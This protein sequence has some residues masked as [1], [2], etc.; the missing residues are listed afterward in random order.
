M[1]GSTL[2]DDCLRRKALVIAFVVC[3]NP[4]VCPLCPENLVSMD[5]GKLLGTENVWLAKG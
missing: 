4:A 5:M 1:E 3:V 2:E